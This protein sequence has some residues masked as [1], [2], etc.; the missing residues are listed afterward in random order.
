MIARR[1]RKRTQSTW[2]ALGLSV[3]L[4]AITLDFLQPLAHAAAMR[5]GAL[6]S[7][8]RALWTAF[9][10]PGVA[11]DDGQK[12][13][14]QTSKAHQC[15]LGLAQAATVAS[16]PT[17]FVA[18]EPVAADMAPSLPAAHATPADIR[19]GPCRPRGPPS[20]A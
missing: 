14:S 7:M 11:Q 10:T 1:T 16:P 8:G 20:L 17:V 13:A 15:C 12:P 6:G 3:A 19:D 18:V 4:F 9:C 2:R 5:D